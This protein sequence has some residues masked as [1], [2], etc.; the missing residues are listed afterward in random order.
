MAYLALKET[1]RELLASF[2]DEHQLPVLAQRI[3][4]CKYQ[5]GLPRDRKTEITALEQAL[6]ANCP[7]GLKGVLAKLQRCH[8]LRSY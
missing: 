7:D 8:A 2:A 6:L 5:L 4:A 1:E 3:R